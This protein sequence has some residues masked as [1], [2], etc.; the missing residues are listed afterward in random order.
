MVFPSWL[1]PLIVYKDGW[2]SPNN[3]QI[4]VLEP[5]DWFHGQRHLEILVRFGTE[6]FQIWY[7]GGTLLHSNDALLSTAKL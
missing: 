4:P 1:M 6:R 3:L 5:R 2:T 7:V